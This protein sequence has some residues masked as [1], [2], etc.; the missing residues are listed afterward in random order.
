[1]KHQLNDTQ[2]DLIKDIL[3]GKKQDIGVT[4][5]DNRKFI[6]AVLWIART[7]AHWRALPEAFGNWYTAYTRY[8]RWCN[9]GVWDKVFKALRGDP[10]WSYTLIDS[11]II[12]A[13]QHAAGAKGGL[14]VRPSV[15]RKSASQRKSTA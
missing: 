12:R 13:H 3:P 14:S 7:G 8:H 10:D 9:K 11:T 1:M 2:W 5:K 15:A 6:E 4:A